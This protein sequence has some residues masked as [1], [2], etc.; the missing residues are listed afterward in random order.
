[1][2]IEQKIATALDSQYLNDLVWSQMLNALTNVSTQEQKKLVKAVQ[3]GQDR[4]LGQDVR[5]IVLTYLNG[6]ALAEADEMMADDVL[7]RDELDRILQ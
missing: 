3:K 1:M 6:L 2:T 7:D 5:N 4:S